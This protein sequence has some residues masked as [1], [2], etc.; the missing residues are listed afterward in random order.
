[1]AKTPESPTPLT[2]REAVKERGVAIIATPDESE[3][4]LF[5]RSEEGGM[6]IKLKGEIHIALSPSVAEA[7]S[8]VLTDTAGVSYGLIPEGATPNG[9][10]ESDKSEYGSQEESGTPHASADESSVNQEEIVVPE[11]ENKKHE[12]VGNPVYNAKYRERRSGKRIADFHI[13]THPKE[14]VTHYYRIRAFDDLAEKVRDNVRKGQKNVQV[15]AYGPKYWKGRKKTQDGW[16]EE[17]IEGYYAGFVSTS[18]AKGKET[19]SRSESDPTSDTKKVPSASSGLEQ[20]VPSG[21]PQ[22]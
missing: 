16:K 5:K 10:A 21:Q 19:A 1:M 13:A 22:D 8:A 20:E 15:M 9:T 3:Q 6:S 18:K 4:V 11:S 17:L 2:H 7:S 12:F 14:G